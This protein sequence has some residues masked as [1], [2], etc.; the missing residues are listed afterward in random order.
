VR[1]GGIEYRM[2]TRNQLLR[3]VHDPGAIIEFGDE[4]PAAREKEE[5]T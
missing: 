1:I 4:P 5:Q 3:A 2:D